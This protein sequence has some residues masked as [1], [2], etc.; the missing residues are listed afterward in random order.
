MF[1]DLVA[2]DEHALFDADVAE[3]LDFVGGVDG[4]GRVA[5]RIEDQQAGA[6]GDGGAELF[7]GDLELRLVGGL[8]MTGVAPASL[9]ISG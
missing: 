4:A 8:E 6:R 1:V 9:A 2:H 5:G 7:R 3:R